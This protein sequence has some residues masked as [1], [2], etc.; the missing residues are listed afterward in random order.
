MDADQITRTMKDRIRR[1]PESVRKDTARIEKEV[2]RW[3]KYTRLPL[4]EGVSS[5]DT[6]TSRPNADDELFEISGDLV[7]YCHE[8]S[9]FCLAECYIHYSISF[10]VA[11]A[12]LDDCKQP[13][14]F[15]TFLLPAPLFATES[16][17]WNHRIQAVD[18]DHFFDFVAY[19]RRHFIWL[20]KT[21]LFGWTNHRQM[22]LV[23]NHKPFEVAVFYPVS[24][25][26]VFL[27]RLHS[28]C[29]MFEK[30][31]P[32]S[33]VMEEKRKLFGEDKLKHVWRG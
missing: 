30:T 32:P 2:Q 16:S 28:N 12:Y 20:D 3:S 19:V 10:S 17:E 11:Q 26:G 22:S 21:L 14:E 24:T 8:W 4:K 29:V 13:A 31:A 33:V 15:R 27:P 25:E 5:P 23:H 18:N 1:Y 9:F 7:D 6:I